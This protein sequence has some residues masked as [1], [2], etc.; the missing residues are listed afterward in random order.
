M[1]SLTPFFIVMFIEFSNFLE[2][3]QNKMP[4]ME[5]TEV[6]PKLHDFPA[7][8]HYAQDRAETLPLERTVV[9]K[10]LHHL[11]S[12]RKKLGFQNSTSFLTGSVRTDFKAALH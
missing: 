11:Q 6:W 5:P 4:Q 10:S 7:F 9:T 3:I 2:N 1:T 12:Q 8:C